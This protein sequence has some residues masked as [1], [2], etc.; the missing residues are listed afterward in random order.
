MAKKPATRFVC[1]NCGAISSAWAGR[2][3]QCGE[4]NTL[5]EEVDIVVGA[6]NLASA[7][8]LTPSSVD[9]VVTHDLPRLISGTSEIDD[10]FGGG[11]VAGSVNLIAGQPGIGKSTLLLQLAYA[12]AAK[13]PV[14]YVSGE[15]SA[16]QVGLRAERLGT[17]RPELQIATST[18]TD[19]TAATIAA[20]MPFPMT[21]PI[22]ESKTSWP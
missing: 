10:V 13:V 4:W 15:E 8:A 3:G 21:S 1:S 2:C 19:D 16:H 9:K 18:S 11:I 7:S 5:T 14:L 20:G 12:I 6:R 22:T 17:L